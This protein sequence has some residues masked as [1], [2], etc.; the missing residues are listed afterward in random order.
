MGATAMSGP[1]AVAAA[2][3]VLVALV[4]QSSAL[5]LLTGA[6]R[7]PDLCLLVVVAVGW[8]AGATPG[9]VTGFAAGLALDLA[10]P[11]DHLAG[12]WALAFVLAGYLAGLAG[13]RTP[14]RRLAGLARIL[15][16]VAVA[17]LV[18]TSVFAFS[19]MVFGELSW[20]VPELLRA[21]VTSVLV[22]VAAAAVVVPVT[23]WLLRLP[24][25][26]PQALPDPETVAG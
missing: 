8:S 7:V 11:A 13:E 1:R 3:A 2:L 16:V 17:S 24:T 9:M 4:L 23:V 25:R 15:L 10:P 5:P 21:V 18:A 22:D 20:S 26:P 14:S 12:R 6:A 19:G